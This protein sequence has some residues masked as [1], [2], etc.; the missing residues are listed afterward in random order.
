MGVKLDL[1]DA[2]DRD[3]DLIRMGTVRHQHIQAYID[4]SWETVYEH[5]A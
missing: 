2:L 3:V 5:S 1:S 4:G